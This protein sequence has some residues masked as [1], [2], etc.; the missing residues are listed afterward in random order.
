MRHNTLKRILSVALSLSMS[1]GMLS[2]V[3]VAWGDGGQQ[4]NNSQDYAYLYVNVTKDEV[5][6]NGPDATPTFDREAEKAKVDSAETTVG[7]TKDVVNNKEADE[8]KPTFKQDEQMAAVTEQ[9]NAVKGALTDLENAM[10]TAPAYGEGEATIPEAQVPKADDPFTTQVKD[11][12]DGLN[13]AQET[14][15]KEADDAQT[16]AK[17]DAENVNKAVT[18]L[19]T[20]HNNLVN[21]LNTAKEEAKTAVDKA[22][23]A[24]GV[25]NTAKEALD[26]EM[27]GKID[28]LEKPAETAP[29]REEGQSDLDFAKAYNA[30]VTECENYNAQVK[31]IKDDYDTALTTLQEESNYTQIQ[32]DFQAATD[33]IAEADKALAA[34]NNPTDPDYR[35]LVESAKNEVIRDALQ[36]YQTDADAYKTAGDAYDG[37]IGAFDE[38]VN[39]ENGY[40]AA[41]NAY[42]KAID[43]HNTAVTTWNGEYDE[44]VNKYNEA[45]TT[46]ENK[47][48]E[49]NGKVDT[50]NNNATSFN[51]AQM[52]KV[53]EELGEGQAAKAQALRDAMAEVQKIQITRPETITNDDGTVE[54]VSVIDESK[55]DEYN[56]AVIAFNE[57]IDAYNDQLVE[58]KLKAV[59]KYFGF[60]E[61]TSGGHETDGEHWYTIGKISIGAGTFKNENNFKNI[62][63]NDLNDDQDYGTD[64]NADRNVKNDDGHS[65]FFGRDIYYWDKKTVTDSDGNTTTEMVRSDANLKENVNIYA[66]GK[67]VDDLETALKNNTL[68]RYKGGKYNS[69]ETSRKES[70]F[71]LNRDIDR[72]VLKIAYGANNYDADGV[73]VLH[74]DAYVRVQQLSHLATLE[75]HI[76]KTTYDK[77]S[78]TQ[79]EENH[80]KSVDESEKLSK[81]ELT[82]DS[83]NRYNAENVNVNVSDEPSFEPETFEHGTPTDI[84]VDL[85]EYETVTVEN[86]VDEPDAPGPIVTPGDDDDDDGDDDDDDTTLPETRT[87]LNETPEAAPDAETETPA[88]EEETLPENEVPLE[89]TPEEEEEE[90]PEDEVPLADAPKTG[91]ISV[92]WY[93]ALLVSAAGLLFVVTT[94]RKSRRVSE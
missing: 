73:D 4:Q 44:V 32:A 89:E 42:N 75:T 61:G 45:V 14:T 53:T 74:I 46:Y 15:T 58:D 93:A 3:G 9:E 38:A 47:V 40:N 11:R 30:W 81:L 60:P 56:K 1:V 59:D 87:P 12:V 43:D 20:A 22:N 21:T 94:D 37:K 51:E 16:E 49:Y 71:D 8:N 90:L 27:Q 24:I 33:A 34:V 39:G 19:E 35:K 29:V 31:D 83:L 17:A 54:T 26:S 77:V 70:G 68:D 78:D 76:S 64:K 72:W 50:H 13:K 91:D 2:S 84:N 5:K 67:S 52:T 7:T 62:L 10:P 25:Y 65:K 18:D 88:P 41:V 28:A 57:A 86:R 23:A 36:K 92:M 79:K 66:D 80:A 69:T 85:L 48:D 55:I 6:E 63:D 82:S